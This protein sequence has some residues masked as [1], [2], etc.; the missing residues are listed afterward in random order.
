MSLTTTFDTAPTR[1]VDDQ[2]V[3]PPEG[4]IKRGTAPFM[5]VTLALFS[6]G[7]AT[8]ALLYCVQPKL[9]VLSHEFVVSPA[10]R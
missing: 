5:R 7:R 3:T 4:F 8:L 2:I 9:P 10:S 1:H 6:A